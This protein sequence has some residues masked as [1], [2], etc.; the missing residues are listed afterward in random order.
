M[1]RIISVIFVF[2]LLAAG[3]TLDA[4]GI[5]PAADSAAVAQMRERMAEIRK[6]RPTVALVLSGGGAKGAAHIG[7]IR[8]LESLDIPVDM[9]LM[10]QVA[11][12]VLAQKQK[13]HHAH[14]QLSFLAISAQTTWQLRTL[15]W[16]LHVTTI[17]SLK[18]GGCQIAISKL[19]TKI[20]LK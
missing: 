14:M 13:M 20:L 18:V 12:I 6:N 15:V 11:R 9:V 2:C 7:V 4:R 3:V 19:S 5:D 1:K 17:L 10:R 8:Y 16:V